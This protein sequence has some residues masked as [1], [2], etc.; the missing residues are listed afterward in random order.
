MLYE[1]RDY[2]SAKVSL[3][4]IWPNVSELYYLNSR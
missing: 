1:I 3:F 2:K 4:T